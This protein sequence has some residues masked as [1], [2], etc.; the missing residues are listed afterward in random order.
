MLLGI[1]ALRAA[2]K[3]YYD[4]PNMRIT[5]VLAANAFLRRDYRP[6]WSI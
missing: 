2:K 4:G 3:I 6:G 1:V 5:N